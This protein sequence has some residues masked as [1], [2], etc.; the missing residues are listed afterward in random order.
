MWLG[1]IRWVGPK[2][3]LQFPEPLLLRPQY[4]LISAVCEYMSIIV[5]WKKLISN[6]LSTF[7]ELLGRVCLGALEILIWSRHRLLDI[8]HIF[9][10][11]AILTQDKISLVFMQLV[12]HF[13]CLILKGFH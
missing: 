1:Y 13:L 4:F 5:A 6:N 10:S 9:M 7:T 11:N 2:N 8:T 12:L 3:Y